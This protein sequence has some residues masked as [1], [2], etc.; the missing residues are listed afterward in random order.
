MSE[1]MIK[2]DRLSIDRKKPEMM[3]KI[4]RLSIDRKEERAQKKP[5]FLHAPLT[6]VNNSFHFLI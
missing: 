2:I 6:I 1:M 3:I 5:F 4:D